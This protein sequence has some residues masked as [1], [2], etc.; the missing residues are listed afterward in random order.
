MENRNENNAH[1]IKLGT[2]SPRF[3][4]PRFLFFSLL[5]LLS[6]ELSQSR[7]RV[8]RKPIRGKIRQFRV[9]WNSQHGRSVLERERR[10]WNTEIQKKREMKDRDKSQKKKR[11]DKEQWSEK[12]KRE[13]NEYQTERKS[14]A[15][16]VI[17][18][19][20]FFCVKKWLWAPLHFASSLKLST[21]SLAERREFCFPFSPSF[22]PL[23]CV[24]YWVR[25]LIFCTSSRF[26]HTFFSYLFIMS[27][28]QQ[29]RENFHVRPADGSQRTFHNSKR[30]HGMSQE[31]AHDIDSMQKKAQSKR[32]VFVGESG[33]FEASHPQLGAANVV[34]QNARQ[35]VDVVGVE[36][37]RLRCG[38]L[39]G[40]K[41][42]K[43]GKK[44][45]WK[46]TNRNQ[47]RKR[48]KER[49][50]NA[51]DQKSGEHLQDATTDKER[52]H[53][54]AFDVAP[55]E[56]EDTG[57]QDLYHAQYA[58]LTIISF[59]L[60]LPKHETSADSPRPSAS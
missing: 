51:R 35:N 29:E 27:L 23:P 52:E 16:S 24:P 17:S 6:S 33:S 13:R 48:W 43:K 28:L 55:N 56:K 30:I 1:S 3:F 41:Q 19:I 8:H 60:T 9:A 37:P 39:T 42:K 2:F 38:W 26:S 47:K 25:F 21:S 34:Q 54:S 18:S 50:R 10:G 20:R 5:Y 44:R 11:V 31:N 57:R 36:L 59:A 15:F 45:R 46:K 53:Y 12:K 14:N 22:C 7:N 58:T 49:R 40:K 32:V 4:F